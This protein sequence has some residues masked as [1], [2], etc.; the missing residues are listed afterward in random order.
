MS[1]L[2]RISFIDSRI[3]ARGGVTLREVAD[4]FE[5]TQRQARRD[6]EYLVDRLGA[7]IEWKAA[8]R[9]YEYAQV[10]NGLEFADEKALLFYVFARAAAGTIAYVPLAEESALAKL[11]ELVPNSLRE[12]EGAIRYEL[13]AYDP[14]DIEN[15]GLLVRAIAERRCV[16]VEYS[17]ARGA[18]SERRIEAL[19]L[20][21]YAGSWYCVAFDDSKGE[22]RTF[23][24]SRFAKVALSRDKAAA[25]IAPSEIDRF[26]GASYGMFKGKGDRT[27]T[28]RFY[29]SALSIVKDERWHP[30]QRR[31]EG[32]DPR[33]GSFVEL[34]IP[35]SRWEEILGRVLRFG[36]D[37]EASSP[38]EFRELWKAEIRRMAEAIEEPSPAKELAAMG[39]SDPSATAAPR[40]RL[41]PASQTRKAKL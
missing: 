41:P 5:V 7:P 16:D 23:R 28:M 3:R 1:Q 35:V 34:A 17:D 25:T 20:V 26:L 11:L 2:E 33:R 12:A 22:L 36:A 21:N 27:A 18:P 37:A 38:P 40:R 14:A 15:L 6:I 24:L 29:G 13:P 9:R 30:D 19:R 32:S 10:W 31:S 39:G 4:R 8:T